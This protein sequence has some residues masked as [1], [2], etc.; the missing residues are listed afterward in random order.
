MNRVF[1]SGRLGRDPDVRLREGG[2]QVAQFSLAVENN[3][4]D[5]SGK[6]GVQ[7]FDI[8]AERSFATLAQ[9]YLRRGVMVTISGMVATDKKRPYVLVE[10]MYLNDGGPAPEEEGG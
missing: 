1:L 7:W 8:V 4:K 3:Y 2:V 5:R 10:S 9:Q 6:R